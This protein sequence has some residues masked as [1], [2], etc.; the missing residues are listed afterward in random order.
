VTYVAGKVGQALSFDGSTS[1]VRLPDNFLPF[2]TSG[3][4]ATP[5]S[6][7]TWFR[8]S[9][10]GVLLDQEG[11]S[12]G[13]V[14]AVYVGTDGKLRAEPFWGGSAA[15]IVS[16]GTV[17]DGQWHHVALTY[18]GTS[19]TVYLEGAA[20]GT[21]S[22]S[23]TA[24]SSA[25]YQYTLGRGEATGWP[26]TPS[27]TYDYFKGQVDEAAFYNRALSASEVQN[28]YSFVKLPTINVT[29]VPPT[30]ALSGY[31]TGLATEVLTYKLSAT[32]PSPIDTAAGFTYSINWGDGS[33]VQTISPT[34][35]N[36]S[37]VNVNHV[38]VN[39]GTYTVSLTA[40]DEDGGATTITLP[41]T[42]LSVTS[43]NLQTVI[44]QQ[45]SITTQDTNN[46]QAQTMVN[47]VNGLAVQA[48]P[49]TITMQL[50]SG[51]FTDTSGNPHA[52]ITLVISGSGGSTTIVGH[53]PALQVAGGNVIV[54]NLT[55]V[56]DTNSPTL[57]VSGGSVTLRNVDI[58]GTGTGSQPAVEIDSGNVDLGTA[59]DPGGN[60]FND[61][62]TGQLIH[63][64]GGNGVSAVGNT[65][66]VGGTQLTSPYRIKD[67]IFDALN[68]GG[69]GLVTY[70]PGHAYISVK[71]GDIQRGIDAIAPGGTV[72]VE[73]SGSY[74]KYD[75]GSKLVTVQFDG[76]PTL[77][78][79]PN[80]QDPTLLDLI[81]TGNDGNDHIHFTPGGQEIQ[82]QVDGFPNG[83]FNPTGRLVAYGM[84]GNNV[85]QVA[86]GITLPAWLYAGPGNDL[87]Q[88]GGGNDVLVGGGG[89]DTL[90]SGKGRD[91]LIG[92]AGAAHLVGNSG[93]DI[94]IAGTT[95]FDNNEAALAAI[96]AEWTSNRSYADRVANLSGTGTGPSSNGS[97]Y[98]IASGPSATVFDNGAS[99]VLN[100]GGGMD[101]FFANLALDSINGQH[102]SEIVENLG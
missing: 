94:L 44:N 98:L 99:N 88:G 18:D 84:A 13:Y 95:A 79:Q 81:V 51:S 53:S 85:I 4:S 100:G 63:N 39:A 74:K 68:Q 21:K 10:G 6:F 75:A 62:G 15:P 36:G 86:G 90:I 3:T 33:P 40:T 57:V 78:Q 89:N 28:I 20:I 7:E 82:A 77:S 58:E 29:N 65:F 45:G 87:L 24:Y 22:L 46:A 2:P 42:V 17:N 93:D 56:T 27:G 102:D 12:A 69:G 11:L 35:G 16:T 30:P 49:V 26:A 92:G 14:P 9:A 43:A 47:A 91:L 60:T 96:M 83:R 73:A 54:E 48:K 25:G 1:F 38:F 61:N 71:G 5:M 66:Q 37:G 64:A 101:W 23:Q 59:N 55:L 41:V 19:K 50:G 80:P 76:G 31:T 32:D 70:V 8:T 72:N 97:Y 52:G 67:E 34:A